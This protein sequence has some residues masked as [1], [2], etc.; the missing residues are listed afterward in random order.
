M[1]QWKNDNFDSSNLQKNLEQSVL[2]KKSCKNITYFQGAIQTLSMHLMLNL[3]RVTFRGRVTTKAEECRLLIL[4]LKGPQRTRICDKP[5]IRAFHIFSPFISMIFFKK[6]SLLYKD[7]GWKCK[8]Y[9]RCSITY[10]KLW[11]SLMQK[12]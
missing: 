7:E 8:T 2:I 3:P 4:L 11:N 5:V 9:F 10:S 6:R 1:I 12:M